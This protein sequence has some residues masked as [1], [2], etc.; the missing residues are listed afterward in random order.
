[1]MDEETFYLE[2]LRSKF[3][4]INPEEYCLNY[5][6]GRDSHFLFWFI[7]EYLKEDRIRIVSV[8]TLLEH[9]DIKKR[10]DENADIV[11]LPLMKHKDLKKA[12]GIPCFTKQQ[13]EYIRRYQNGSR[14]I[15]TINFIEG[16]NTTKF[17][18]NKRARALL[19]SGQLHKVSGECCKYLKK[20]PLINYQKKNKVKPIIAIRSQEG[21]MRKKINSCFHKNGSFTPIHDLTNDLLKKIEIKFNI[22]VPEIYNVLQR[23]GCM[24]CPYGRN[25]QKELDLLNP[26]Q[27]KF[28]ED[29]FE[30]SYRV[31]HIEVIGSVSSTAKAVGIPEPTL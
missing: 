27:R 22:H 17:R 28:V 1:M 16:I 13:D 10:M 12:F 25:I 9:P 3:A 7:K 15:S 18:L 21:I 6:G 29:Y 30:E 4:K 23:T 14:A 2:D 8:N 19:L 24:G 5:S 31:K 20:Q 26:A 11:L